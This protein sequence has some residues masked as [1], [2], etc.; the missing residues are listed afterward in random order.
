MHEA[1]QHERRPVSLRPR[2]RVATRLDY[3]ESP[4]LDLS[5]GG[6]FIES[7][8]PAAPGT[9]VKLECSGE[10]GILRALGMVAWRRDGAD[11]PT[12]M[13]VRFLR[14][15]P[16]GGAVLRELLANAPAGAASLTVPMSRGGTW[17]VLALAAFMLAGALVILLGSR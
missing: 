8:A 15:E 16:G 7:P 4:C 11:A 2:Y 5:E 17:V 12:G 6:M 14:I 13:G 9:L 1:R 10:H 3:T